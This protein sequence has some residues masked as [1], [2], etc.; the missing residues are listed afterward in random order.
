MHEKD[1][2]EETENQ[3]RGNQTT[4]RS[5]A[6]AFF[7]AHASS[8]PLFGQGEVARRSFFILSPFQRTEK[9]PS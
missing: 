7:L 3:H 1:K 9:L 4:G 5:A 2:A 8:Y 6:T